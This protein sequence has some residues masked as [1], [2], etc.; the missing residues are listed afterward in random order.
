MKF[1]V[2]FLLL[3][4]F[5]LVLGTLVA[6]TLPRKGEEAVTAGLSLPR[7]PLL[8]GS[9][10]AVSPGGCCLAL[11]SAVPCPYSPVTK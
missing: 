9:V 6:V 7:D 5:W 2:S 1:G 3:S 10:M 11:V 8:G 4:A